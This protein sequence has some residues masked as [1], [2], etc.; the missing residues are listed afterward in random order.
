MPCWT[1]SR[2]KVVSCAALQYSLFGAGSGQR[3]T[4]DE[5]GRSSHRRRVSLQH[6][7][8]GSGSLNRNVVDCRPRS[9]PNPTGGSCRTGA[10]GALRLAAQA[11]LT[12]N[13]RQRLT[14][15][16]TEPA[17]NRDQGKLAIFQV[18]SN[19]CSLRSWSPLETAS[20]SHCSRPLELPFIP[21]LRRRGLSR[22]ENRV[23]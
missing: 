17:P 22:G 18:A 4:S 9:V 11:V 14:R 2:S 23:A 6:L 15:F 16:R 20:W 13:A 12:V 19:T 21:P 3:G 1:S 7:L 5:R 10:A 8:R